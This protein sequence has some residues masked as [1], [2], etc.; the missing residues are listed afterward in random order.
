MKILPGFLVFGLFGFFLFAET[1]GAKETRPN[2]VYILADDFGYGDA[3]S[4]NS[5]SK[6]PTPHLNRLAAEGMSFTDAHSPSS[7]C[8][9]TR[10]ATLTG[11]YCWRSQLKTGVLNGYGAPLIEPERPTVASHL[12]AAGYHTAVIGKWHLGLGFVKEESGEWDW[13]KPL[14]Y[15]PVDVGFERSF[16]IPA[17]LDFPPYIYIEGHEITG[18]PDRE[19]EAVSF[20]GY[21]RK[22][23]LGS[24]FSIIDCLDR[25]TGE[26]SAHIEASAKGKKPFFLYFPLTAPHKPVLPHP[27][28]AGKS[29]LG[30]YGDFI[31]QV[32]DV[33]G[34]ILN[35]I[36]E[37]GINENTIVVFTSDNGSFMYRLNEEDGPDHLTDETVQGYYEN[38][39]WANQPWRGTKADV[40]EAGH[41]VPYFVRW[42]KVIS[43]G[44][45]CD[46]EICHTDLFATVAEV[47]EAKLGPAKEMAQDSFSLLPLFREEPKKFKRAP[48]VN[49]SAGGMFAIRNGEWK[50]VLGNGSGGRE[51]PRG[52]RFQG[53]FQ[54]FNLE[55]DPAETTNVYLE[56][57]ALAHEMEGALMEM[58]WQEKSR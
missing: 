26:A 23:E 15:S 41:R 17:S 50:L 32:D 5:S 39:H 37:A 27:R 2:I 11:R 57:L 21:L 33:V 45:V 20:P 9:P 55:T 40:W 43:A 38:N 56:N 47:A 3:Q 13:T 16:V 28:F 1:L 12:K 4:L 10:Y 51:Q 49:H 54:L 8:T 35:A 48:V 18:R 53:P 30:P 14:T 42:P 29:K 52:K 19:Q 25:L 34:Q 22:G 44:S 24:D 46:V 7:V 6:I 58:I 36:D 31:M